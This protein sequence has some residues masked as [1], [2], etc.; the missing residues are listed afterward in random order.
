MFSTNNFHSIEYIYLL[1][2]MRKDD[3]QGTNNNPQ[4]DDGW[5][6]NKNNQIMTRKK[7]QDSCK[8]TTKNHETKKDKVP[9]G[10]GNSEMLEDKESP[11]LFS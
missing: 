2:V 4:K 7:L 6:R 10:V 8:T 3:G 1:Q 5:M 11:N 9:R